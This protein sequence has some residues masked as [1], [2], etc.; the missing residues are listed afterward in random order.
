MKRASIILSE[1]NPE[2]P[3]KFEAEKE[4]LM[5]SIGNLMYGSVE[6]V[7]STAIPGLIAKPVIDIMFGVKSLEASRSAIDILK[8]NGYE[9]SAYKTDVMHWFCKPSDEFRTHHLHLIPYKSS[10]WLE[11]IQ[12]RELLLSDKQITRE[13]AE[14][15][16]NL[17]SKYKEDREAYTTEKWP[18]I[19]K[20]LYGMQS[21]YKLFRNTS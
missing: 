10:L 11:R 1:Y 7:G 19:E 6:H 14:L 20:K 12:F 18:F 3:A 9:Y 13:Y 5:Q 4:N 8:N 21:N 17:A 2:W 16:K 15:K